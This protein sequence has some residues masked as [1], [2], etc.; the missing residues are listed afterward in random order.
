MS[1]FLTVTM[2]M[3]SWPKPRRSLIPV[4]KIH[5]IDEMLD[6]GCEIVWTEGATHITTTGREV[7]T[8]TQLK[9]SFESIQKKLESLK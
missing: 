2:Q 1:E 4:D 7:Y 5:L 9:D 3:D 6:G 8:R